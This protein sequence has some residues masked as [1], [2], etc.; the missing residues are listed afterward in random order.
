MRK[1]ANRTV[2]GASFALCGCLLLGQPAAQKSPTPSAANH[3]ERS[4]E[5]VF[6][7]KPLSGN[8]Y[9]LYGRGGN[10]GFFVGPDAVVVIDSEFKDVAPGI[11]GEIK[12]VTEKPIKFLINTHHH[13]DHVGGNEIFKPFAMILAHD[14]VRTRMLAA[15]TT[16]LRDFPGRLEEARKS[17]NAEMAKFLADQIEWAK[18]VK[19]EEIAAPI[20]TYDSE[21]RIHMGDETIQIWHLPPAHTDGDSVIY[22]EK[23][24][25]LHMG[26]DFFNKVI[27]FIDVS[28]GG[29]ARGYLAALDKVLSRVPSDVVIIPGHGEVTDLA[30]LKSFRQY[31][32][33]LLDAAQKAK[34][35]GKSKDDF[36]K[37]ANLPA[38][39]DYS[40]YKDRFKDNAAAAYDSA[41]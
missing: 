9:A 39:K 33:D 23:A 8:V 40:G 34:S 13:S 28:G 6:R 29:S 19:V 31:I 37:E 4:P 30:G 36:V 38:Y 2:L 22:F 7:V 18:K 1:R 25:V 41:K 26:D 5:D 27:P 21:F 14:N 15:P 24:K 11:V 32:A 12:K 35:S 3:H 10:V 20:L 16:V 17:G